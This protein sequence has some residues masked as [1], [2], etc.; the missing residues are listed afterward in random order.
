MNRT[1][2]SAAKSLAAL[3]LLACSLQATASAQSA[4]VSPLTAPRAATQT[5][6]PQSA[7]TQPSSTQP[8]ATQSATVQTAATQSATART[9]ETSTPAAPG[10]DTEAQANSATEATGDGGARVANSVEEPKSD[11]LT[12]M[13]DAGESERA[14]GPGAAWLMIRTLGALLLIVG[15]LLAA[16]WALRRYGGARFGSSR[17]DAPELS[18]LSTVALGDKRSLAVVRFG[19]K[20]LLIGSTAQGITLLESESES[21]SEGEREPVARSVADLLRDDP[22]PRAFER[23]L[24]DASFRLARTAGA[25]RTVEGGDS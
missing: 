2:R 21:V 13:D 14:E 5:I 12:F 4:N 11:R 22:A 20:T 16:T 23:E 25:W 8:A 15:L 6:A 7:T 18:I 10:A 1:R 24:S 3:A 19:D 17:A 9:G